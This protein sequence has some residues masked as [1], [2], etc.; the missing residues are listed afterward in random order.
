MIP[1]L[2]CPGRLAFLCHC[3]LGWGTLGWGPDN[4]ADLGLKQGVPT[5]SG[6]WTMA[7]IDMSNVKPTHL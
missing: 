1:M 3:D 4:M 7:R 2:L 6:P 5:G